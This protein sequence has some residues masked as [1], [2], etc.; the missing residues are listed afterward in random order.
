MRF[1]ITFLLLTLGLCASANA[2]R[3][4]DYGPTV[5]LTGTLRS[6][7]FAGPPNFE[8]LKRG[9]RKETA[10][11]LSLTTPN[12]VVGRNPKDLEISVAG[13]RKMQ[14]VVTN[15]THWK[16]IRRLKGKRAVVSG[17]LFYRHSGFHQTKVLIGVTGIRGPAE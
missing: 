2:Q 13:I 9:D 6:Q 4:L 3:C 5:T 7:V 12:C 14:L 10:L 8:S 16:T 17:T 1:T 15:D 11:I